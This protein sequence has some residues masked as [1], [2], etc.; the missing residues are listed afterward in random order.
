M[1]NKVKLSGRNA[2]NIFL[3]IINDFNIL[4]VKQDY[5][6]TSDYNYFFTT[7][8]ITKTQEVLNILKRK[9]SLETA[10]MT[11]GSIKN[12]RLSFFFGIKGYNCFYG[13]YNED[14][15]YVYKVGTFKFQNKDFKDLYKNKSM[16]TIRGIIENGN[17]KNMKLLQEI[18]VDFH[19]LF[20][21]IESDIEILDEYRIKNT[22]KIDIFKTEDRDETKLRVYLTQWSRNFKWTDKCY[23][24]IYLTE[25]YVHFYIKLIK[26]V[27]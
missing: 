3:D 10:Y 21:K 6:N 4:F 22:F 11:L 16:K 24:F 12:M 17:L 8:R 9:K 19:T 2:F 27:Q 26:D 1:E 13:F 20:D 7:E 25:K 14:N 23:Y 18:K 5:Y 15:R